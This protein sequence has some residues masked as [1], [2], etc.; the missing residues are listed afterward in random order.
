VESL[1][2]CVIAALAIVVAAG[3][4]K[5]EE[6]AAPAPVQTD[7][8]AEAAAAAKAALES[9]EADTAS[10]RQLIVA[11]AG[12]DADLDAAK[13]LLK[14]VL[15]RDRDYAPAYLELARLEYR[16]GYIGGDE[17]HGARVENAFKFLKHAVSFGADLP[18]AHA[19]QARIHLERGEYD[20][21]EVSLE[22][23]EL[24]GVAKEQ[25]DAIRA[26]VA[27]AYDN[28][29]EA[30]RLA[31][32]VVADDAASDVLKFEML[33]FI[34]S[35]LSKQ[36]FRA[37]AQEEYERAIE[38]LPDSAWGYGNLASFLLDHEYVEA[39]LENA[40]KA[41][42]INPYP[43]AVRTLARA[44]VMRSE[45]LY[46]LKRN[47]EAE[48]VISSLERRIPAGTA[49]VDEMLGDYYTRLYDATSSVAYLDKA[50]EKYRSAVAAEPEN[51][52][53]ART[54]EFAVARRTDLR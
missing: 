49:A 33:T 53:L 17:R 25:L 38:V 21:A 47:D 42:E 27:A 28:E 19:L 43:G 16:G 20:L 39:G 34:G 26:R 7:T 18:E 40:E 30:V 50:I 31:R 5:E 22:K 4:G 52:D 6:A 54:L 9:I 24:A 36:G 14:S 15:T 32:E 35:R 44:T 29:R 12:D 45:E 46:R 51:T 2:I 8:A 13:E 37:E 41:F 1:R 48:R 11:Y 10:A 23:A 3:C